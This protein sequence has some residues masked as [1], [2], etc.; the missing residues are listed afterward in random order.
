MLRRTEPLARRS[1]DIVHRQDAI[2]I[3]IIIR[4]QRHAPTDEA[5][6]PAELAQLTLDQGPAHPRR[7]HVPSLREDADAVEE[8]ASEREAG[9]VVV[10]QVDVGVVQGSAGEVGGATDGATVGDFDKG[11][12]VVWREGVECGTE[13]AAAA[14]D[15]EGTVKRGG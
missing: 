4:R 8:G 1:R 12:D 5:A 6:M 13:D 2:G 9:D 3:G 7:G 10:W 14:V 15:A 11:A